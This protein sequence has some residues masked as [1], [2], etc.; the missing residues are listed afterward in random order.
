M[1]LLFRGES[2]DPN[3]YYHSGVD[4][5][6]SFLLLSGKRKLLLVSKMNE[7]L[8]RSSFRGKV[9]VYRNATETVARYTRGRTVLF[10]ANSVSAALATRLKKSCRLR[11]HSRELLAMR[12]RKKPEEVACI[13][14][15]VHHTKEI[16][17]SLDFKTARTEVGLKKQ[18]LMATLDLGLEPAFE[19][20]VSTGPNTSFPHYRS[21]IRKLGS[22]VKVDY[23]VRYRN[24]CSDLTRCFILDGDR[25]KKE[26][27]E[28]LQ[29]I[30]FFIVDSLPDLECGKDVTKLAA[31]LMEKAGFP[32]MIHCIGHGIGLDVHEMPSLCFSSEDPLAG[33]TI[34]IEPG[35]YL[36]KYGMRY[37]ETVYNDGKRARIL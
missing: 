6:H 7:S 32:D 13:R 26:Q 22:I 9:I 27:Y 2:F 31:E 29:D 4:I 12:A 11:D 21:G 10:D 15:A 16:F 24:Y 3:F 35:F 20:I 1:I 5:D 19:P 36:K 28:R 8:A 30:C 25:R 37:E 17:E 18:L 14:R 23:G 34:A 33:C